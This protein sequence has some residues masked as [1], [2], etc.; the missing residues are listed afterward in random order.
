MRLKFGKTKICQ[1]QNILAFV[2]NKTGADS[3]EWFEP[4]EDAGN[5]KGSGRK[6]KQSSSR[7]KTGTAGT[8]PSR[9][10]KSSSKHNPVKP[11]VPSGKA[12]ASGQV[13][14]ATNTGKQQKKVARGAVYILTMN[15]CVNQPS[16]P[17][18]KV[19][20][21]DR[22]ANACRARVQELQT[23]NPHKLRCRHVFLV[24]NPLSAE[25]G[26]H[27]DL[28]G[29]NLHLKTQ[30]GCDGGKDWFLFPD[31]QTVGSLITRV[32]Q[33]ITAGGWFVEEESHDWVESSINPSLFPNQSPQFVYNS[34]WRQV[35]CKGDE[36]QHITYN[37]K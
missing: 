8:Q 11:V 33:A 14:T 22:T 21:T 2:Y 27:N 34:K 19:G 12:G 16:P 24:T 23:G 28:K 9:T 7:H 25:T 36:L 15:S 30:R 37:C 18:G 13:T 5:P 6:T 20:K 31:S 1:E 17:F 10:S 29:S 26:A 3:S 32:R 35:P 4:A